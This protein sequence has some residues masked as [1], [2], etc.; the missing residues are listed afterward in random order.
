MKIGVSET[1]WAE[2]R[3]KAQLRAIEI[4][5][6][7]HTPSS[8]RVYKKNLSGAGRGISADILRLG[9]SSGPAGNGHRMRRVEVEHVSGLRP[10]REEISEKKAFPRYG[11]LVFGC[12]SGDKSHR[13][14][15]GQ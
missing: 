15:S 12:Q 2:R 13:H 4:V 3:G 9:L 10:E 14:F 11:S 5:K 6:K 1:V 7:V 8:V